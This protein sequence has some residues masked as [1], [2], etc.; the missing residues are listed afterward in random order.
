MPCLFVRD[1][2]DKRN[3][4]ITRAVTPGCEW[5]LAGEGIASRKWDGAACA[6]ID[7]VFYKRYDVKINP[8]TGARKTIPTGAVPCGEPDPVTGHWP[9]WVEVR[10]DAPEDKHFAAATTLEILRCDGTYELVGPPVNGNHDGV[11]EL[12]LRRHGEDVLSPPRDFDGLRTFVLAHAYEGIV[13]A[14][15]D[16]RMCKIRRDDFGFDW[17]V[18]CAADEIV[19]DHA[20]E[21]LPAITGCGVKH[22]PLHPEDR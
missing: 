10:L 9:H 11:A 8:K 16:G 4:V 21:Q 18:A 19:R 2:A 7:G 12:T 3:P 22:L 1:F 5:V 17:P 20:D 13:F 6:Y 15:P 14:H